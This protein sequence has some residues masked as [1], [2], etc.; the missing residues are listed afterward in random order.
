MAGASTL[1]A[2]SKRF[3]QT[4]DQEGNSSLIVHTPTATQ[5]ARYLRTGP[6][7][8][9]S[10]LFGM[11]LIL[12]KQGER[13][14]SS[15]GRGLHIPRHFYCY[16]RTAEDP[17]PPFAAFQ[18]FCTSLAM[19]QVQPRQGCPWPQNAGPLLVMSLSLG[20]ALALLACFGSYHDREARWASGCACSLCSSLLALHLASAAAKIFCFVAEAPDVLLDVLCRTQQ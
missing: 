3:F 20:S 9:Q 12:W 14:R 10:K 2:N 8:A 17:G 18:P 16:G 15:R 5:Q 11:I 1:R 7:D 6:E 19:Q 4:H 13:A